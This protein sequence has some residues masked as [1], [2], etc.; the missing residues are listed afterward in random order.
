M[1]IKTNNLS[2]VFEPKSINELIALKDVSLNFSQGEY[3]GI[4]GQTGSG[5]TTFIEHLN[6]LSRPT[7]GTVIISYKKV[8]KECKKININKLKDD[9]WETI[10][11]E[12][13]KGRRKIKNILDIRSK[14]GIVFQFAEYQLFEE[15]IEKDISFGP[16]A[17]G[18]TKEEAKELALKYIKLVGLSEEFLSRSPFSLS[19]GQKRRVALAGIL[20]MEP[21][22]IILDEP[23]AGL[24]PEGSQ[25]MYKIFRKLYEEGKT[26]IVVT[27]NL[28]D[29]LRETKRTIIFRDGKVVA[30]G[31]TN[32][33][34]YNKKLLEENK[35]EVP[36]LVSLVHK[37]N[38]KKINKPLSIEEL[39]KQINK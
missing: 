5:K 38:S 25:A 23:T 20:A 7:S 36:Q 31:D 12:I 6:A 15:T 2:K 22:F 35:L 21:D 13:K 9:D 11:R 32:E 29:V 17:I 33:V 24:D 28:D 30:D 37:I 27:H 4:I 34:L 14:V 10:E 8:K 3:I 39:V 1:K 19:G 16:L 26:L 18:K